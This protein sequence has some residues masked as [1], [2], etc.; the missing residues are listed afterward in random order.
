[1][2]NK[3]KVF[4]LLLIMPFSGLAQITVGPKVGVN[5]ATQFKSDYSVPK[6]GL[7]YG[8]A[9]NIP[10]VSSISVHGELLVSQKGYK[11]V[12]KGDTIFDELT[13]SYLEIPVLAKYTFDNV[14]FDFYGMGG[15][16]WSYWTKGSY[17]SSI[18]GDNIIYE[19]YKFQ[20]DY[21]LDGYKDN[22]NDFGL[23]VEAGVAYDNLGSGIITL[24]IRY[25]HGLLQTN[26]HQN[27]PADLVLKKNKVLSISLTYFMFL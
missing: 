20:T 17:K 13:A 9:I 10:I 22:R 12:Y 2:M 27:P 25:T 16:C 26:N 19:D 14:N 1:M 4:I 6:T 23:V 5:L 15:V 3:I 21:D 11:E 18:D 24:G 7:V 8:G